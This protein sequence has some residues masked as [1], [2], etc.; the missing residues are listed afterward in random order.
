VT[1]NA[2]RTS[3]AARRFARSACACAVALAVE[4]Q[5]AAP[6]HLAQLAD[7]SLEQLADI[8]VTSVSRREQRLADAAASVYVITGDDIRRSGVRTLPEALRLAP[9]LQVAR[10]D[11]NQYAI[12]ARGFGNVLAN[13]LLVM[14]DG[15]TVYSPLFS[16]V[17]WEARDVMIEDVERIEVVSGPGTTLWGT[18]AVNGVINVVTRTARATQGGLIAAGGGNRDWAT[19]L[20]YGGAAGTGHYRVYARAVGLED[21]ERADGASVDD[22]S[23]RARIGF[24]Y[25]RGEPGDALTVAGD[26]YTG[27]IDQPGGEREIAGG[28]LRAHLQRAL[29]GALVDVR[30]YYDY[31]HLDQGTFRENLDT[32]DIDAQARFNVHG[33]RLV[34]GGGYRLQRDRT[35]G[36]GSQVFV[37]ADRSID[38]AY[39][40]VHDEYALTP[41]V[42]LI[43]GIK[44]EHNEY[45]GVEWLPDLRIRWQ[46]V[47][48]VTLWGA[49]SRAVRAP[50]RIDR[51]LFTPARPPFLLNGGPNFDSEVANVFELGIH[52][53][54]APRVS[55]SATA[56]RHEWKRLR[57][58]APFPGG[59]FAFAND[60]EGSTSG[61][62]GW[63][64]WSPLDGWRLSA[65]GTLLRQRLHV[66]PG[67]VDLGGLAAL[68]N[69]PERSFVF[70][71]SLDLPHRQELDLIVRYVGER[72]NPLVPAYTA[73][74]L[75]WA[76]HV[77]D[78]LELSLTAENLTD[79]RHAEW[80]PAGNRVEFERAFFAKL[81]AR[82]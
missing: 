46:P 79:A 30:A 18:N 75:R 34:A 24:R 70:R 3:I 49:A 78:R 45:T 77:N 82:L 12:T 35:S 74:D 19:S 4:A 10:A 63:A 21:T 44:V 13:K 62:E 64:T 54:P 26:A 80:G 8:V 50:S 9:N 57:S 53:R 31:T 22:A 68:G 28:N 67:A 51:E 27:D 33:H 41:Q 29:G 15:R 40:F 36:T 66:R 25:D 1:T 72:P 38:T 58:V 60:I 11:A 69:D 20:R 61:L 6:Q 59:G 55:Y 32:F 81:L 14:I 17:F 23:R 7:L 5:A 76:W 52:G 56:F 71:S 47:D 39:L 16:G 37:P 48:A 2:T 73:V 43:G 42:A 65:G